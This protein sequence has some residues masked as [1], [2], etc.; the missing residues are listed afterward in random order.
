MARY[1]EVPSYYPDTKEG[2]HYLAYVERITERMHKQAIH[3]RQ[4]NLEGHAKGNISEYFKEEAK[5]KDD[6]ARLVTIIDRAN[7][8]MN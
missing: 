7:N 5:F 1:I 4:V 3:M 8:I 2:E 6:V